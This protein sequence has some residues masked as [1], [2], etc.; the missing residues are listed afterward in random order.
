MVGFKENTPFFYDV[1]DKNHPFHLKIAASVYSYSFKKI[2]V[3]KIMDFTRLEYI[4]NVNADKGWAYEKH[5]LGA[6]FQLNFKKGKG[7]DTH[8]LN[9]PKG[10]L[11]ILSQKSPIND[12]RYLTHV[13]ELV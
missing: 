9:L 11:I 4:K 12:E 10:A 1:L 6:Y 8:A 13:V 3:G 5:P 2:F 7:V